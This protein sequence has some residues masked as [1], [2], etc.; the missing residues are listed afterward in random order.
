MKVLVSKPDHLGD[1]AL[2]LPVLWELVQHVGDSS[3]IRVMV[4][5]ANLE[6]GRLLPWLP[7]LLPLCLPRYHWQKSSLGV[8]WDVIRQSLALREQKF[9]WGVNLIGAQKDRWGFAFLKMAGC[10]NC[11]PLTLDKNETAIH[12]T[13]RLARY[14]PAEWGISGSSR[15][16][17]FMPESFQWRGGGPILLA[18]ATRNLAKAWPVSMWIELI[19]SLPQGAVQVLAPPDQL[20]QIEGWVAGRAPLLKVQ[21][22][23]ETL[24]YLRD[25]RAAV[26]LDTAVA[27][28]A[29]LVGTPT[30]QLFSGTTLPERWGSLA[31]GR[32][33]FFSPPCSPCH[34]PFC[35]H[36]FHQC[37][38]SVSPQN[39]CQSLEEVQN[40]KPRL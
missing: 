34:S 9:E 14:F 36:S 39:V 15:P 29:W 24:G 22:I 37:M 10:R 17:S 23:A 7:P 6:W 3:K 5:P 8:R 4:Q 25:C 26:V 12:E 28:Y 1:F 21:S 27:H 16:L 11:L 13:L 32:R 38:E 35:P 2:A 31:P 40:R 19:E 30:V 20:D 18:P 33:L